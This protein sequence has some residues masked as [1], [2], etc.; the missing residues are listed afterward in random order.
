MDPVAL[1]ALRFGVA[2]LAGGIVAVIAQRLAFG[3][4]L[5]L[6]RREHERQLAGLRRALVAEV[7]ENIARLGVGES[8]YLPLH[9]ERS[10]WDAARAAIVPET[11][12]GTLIS[13]YT[14]GARLSRHLDVTDQESALGRS[15]NVELI[16]RLGEEARLAFEASRSAL[17]VISP[18]HAERD[19]SPR[20]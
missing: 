15:I 5:E 16:Q 9:V 4:A 10:A 8:R 12:L 19:Q 7:E 13:A 11:S 1:E 20:I 14:K 3:H 18:R 6:Q 2:I 17:T